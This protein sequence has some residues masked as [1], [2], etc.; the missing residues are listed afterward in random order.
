MHHPRQS[1]CCEFLHSKQACSKFCSFLRESRQDVCYPPKKTFSL[2]QDWF[3]GFIIT[4]IPIMAGTPRYHVVHQ[5]KY[6]EMRKS[7]LGSRARLTSHDAPRPA[8]A[9][10][11]VYLACQ[12]WRKWLEHHPNH[13]NRDCCV[14]NRG[15]I[16]SVDAAAK[17]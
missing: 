13:F 14:F 3:S 9:R 5:G 12:I 15:D 8:I 2:L 16:L 6:A 7:L 17:Q 11:L 1:K 10:T 4:G